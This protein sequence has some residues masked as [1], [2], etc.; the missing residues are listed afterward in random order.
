MRYVIEVLPAGGDRVAGTVQREGTERP[1]AFCG[2]LE[3]LRLL[4]PPAARPEAGA[5]G[6]AS[7][8]VVN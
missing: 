5:F 1:A 4:E 8:S 6:H 7:R 3:L 2:W